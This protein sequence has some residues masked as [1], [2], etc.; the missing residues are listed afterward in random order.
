MT[1]VQQFVVTGSG[2]GVSLT[3]DSTNGLVNPPDGISFDGGSG[4]DN[5]LTLKGA[6]G[7][8]FLPN[9]PTGNSS[10][11]GSVQGQSYG[12]LGPEA[13]TYQN[14]SSGNFNNAIPQLV[15][16]NSVPTDADGLQDVYA[17]A[18]QYITNAL[19]TQT[20]A[21]LGNSIG[22]ALDG[23]DYGTAE[24][25]ADPVVIAGAA[26]P[27]SASSVSDPGTSIVEQLFEDG[28]GFS[29][30]Q[31]GTSITTVAQLGAALQSFDPQATFNEDDSTDTTTFT[32][33][34]QKTL[35]GEAVLDGLGASGN[36][37]LG[38][39]VDISTR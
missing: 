3:I 27:V 14:V 33:N 15:A 37:A 10:G 4:T 18:G 16:D 17:W 34:L 20:T 35:S 13:F 19:N 38:G 23:V 26:V 32:I 31:L 28:T 36:L 30:S 8:V 1:S 22:S 24:A 39:I 6:V 29:L 9:Q 12:S 2:G 5:T 25:V 11:S 21:L 7:D